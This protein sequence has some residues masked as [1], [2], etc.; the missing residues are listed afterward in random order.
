MS[1]WKIR[2]VDYL[3]EFLKHTFLY[4]KKKVAAEL[5]QHLEIYEVT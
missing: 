1:F 4:F 2:V 3:I 5:Q